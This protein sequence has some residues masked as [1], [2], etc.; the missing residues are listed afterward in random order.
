MQLVAWICLPLCPHLSTFDITPFLLCVDVL[1][2][3]DLG[4]NQLRL[5]HPCP[6][7]SMSYTGKT[8]SFIISVGFV[9]GWTHCWISHYLCPF[10]VK[11][12]IVLW[13]PVLSQSMT[14]MLMRYPIAKLFNC[15]L[16]PRL[17][18]QL[19]LR[20]STKGTHILRVGSKKGSF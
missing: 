17:A 18:V 8:V 10:V 16:L 19:D 13:T 20:V 12:I 4:N 1:Y 6:Q 11:C 7:S 2:G 3:W 9:G 15:P 14:A 5:I